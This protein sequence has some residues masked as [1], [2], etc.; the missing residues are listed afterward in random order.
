MTKPIT[1]AAI[2]AATVV[3]AI[4]TVAIANGRHEQKTSTGAPRIYG[5]APATT[6][7]PAT[8]AP[9]TAAAAEQLTRRWTTA[10]DRASDCPAAAADRRTIVDLAA[11]A[12]ASQLAEQPPRPG[13]QADCHPTKIIRVTADGPPKADGTWI[14]FVQHKG[15]TGGPFTVTLQPTTRGLRVVAIDY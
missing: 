2:V 4:G 12:L 11:G 7:P 6:P 1:T 14:V 5:G 3:A 13:A 10:F 8:P 9:I 15:A